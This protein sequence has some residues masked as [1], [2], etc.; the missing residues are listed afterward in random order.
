MQEK[1]NE[2]IR[3]MIA[4]YIDVNA[5]ELSMDA[6]LDIEYDMDSTEMTEFAKK[7][8][9]KYGISIQRSERQDWVSGSDICK[10]VARKLA[11]SAVTV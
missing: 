1:I 5:S 10:F 2:E 4:G 8:E 7:I 6:D 11:D 9:Q 3:A